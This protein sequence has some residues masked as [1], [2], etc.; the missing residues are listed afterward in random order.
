M[1]NIEIPGANAKNNE[2]KKPKIC[3]VYLLITYLLDNN[4]NESNNI[5]SFQNKGVKIFYSEKQ[6][7]ENN[8]EYIAIIENNSEN[9]R[10]NKKYKLEFKIGEKDF[11]IY[12]EYNNAHFIYEL[13]FCSVDSFFK[14]EKQIPQFMNNSQKFIYFFNSIEKLKQ[15]NLFDEL[16]ND[17]INLYSTLPKY[18]FLIN[19]FV[20]VY[21][22][23]NVCPKLLEEFK[24]FNDKIKNNI[25]DKKFTYINFEKYLSDYNN[26][27]EEIS[28]NIDNIITTNSFNSVQF[29]G[30]VLCYLNNYNLE[31]FSKLIEK[32]SSDSKSTLLKIL[33]IYNHFFK[34]IVKFDKNILIELV[35]FSAEQFKDNFINFADKG[36][37]YLNNAN[38]FLNAI[39][40]N[41]EQIILIKD[42]KAILIPN[43]E[44]YSNINLK[45]FQ[46]DF[47]EI[48]S[49]S[50]KEGKLLI[51][52]PNNFWDSLLK[53]YENSTKENINNCKI[54]R[55]NFN[56]YYEL[57][58][59]YCKSSLIK[60]ETEKYYTN[61][62]FAYIL[63]NSI[64]KYL[65]EN[66]DMKNKEIV[67][68]IMEYDPYYFPENKV[69]IN[70][71]NPEIFQQLNISE[72]D[73]DFKNFYR[74]YNFEQIF[75]DKLDSY[76]SL[77]ISKIKN[78][79]HFEIIIDLIN[80]DNIGD[81]LINFVDLLDKKYVSLMKRIDFINESKEEE[82]IN[83]MVNP[84][85]KLFKF[86][87]QHIDLE[88]LKKKINL[89]MNERMKIE[90]YI[91]L[92]EIDEKGIKR[93]IEDK[94]IKNLNSKNLVNLI[95]FMKSIN[96][97]EDYLNII[98]RLLDKYPISEEIFLSKEEDIGIELLILLKENNLLIKLE[99]NYYYANII[100]LFEK[101]YN[102]IY[103]KKIKIKEL[104]SF[105]S[106]NEEYI[107]KKLTLLKNITNQIFEPKREYNNLKSTQT[108]IK[109]NYDNLIDI[110]NALEKYH[111][112]TY[113][114]TLKTIDSYIDIINNGELEKYD[115]NSIKLIIG[116][117]KEKCTNINNVKDSHIF[118]LLYRHSDIKDSEKRF[119]Q[120]FKNFEKVLYIKEE[121]EGEKD[122]EAEELLNLIKKELTDNQ[123]E[124]EK[125]L[126]IKKI[127]KVS[128]KYLM[129]IEGNRHQKIINSIF[130]FFS[131]F[132][133][134]DDN[135]NKIFSPK[136]KDIAKNDPQDL[137]QYLK[138]LKQNEIYDYSKKENY[139]NFFL[140][141]Y[142]LKEAYN[143]LLNETT[144]S[145]KN[146][147]GKIDPNNQKIKF[148]DIEDT[149]YCVGFFQEIKKK[150]NNIEIFKFI[151]EISSENIERFHIF[152][153]V[154]PSIIELNQNNELSI[155]LYG[156]IQDITNNS[157]FK[158]FKDSQI[159][160]YVDSK[161]VEKND[162]TLDKLKN[163]YNKIHI[164]PKENNSKT[165]IE[166]NKEKYEE[167]YKTLDNFKTLVNHIEVI[168][169][170][171]D[172]LRTKGSSLPIQIK[173]TAKDSNIE[174]FLRDEKTTF[175][176]IQNYLFNAKNYTITK[177]EEMY[178]EKSNLRFIYG[179]QFENLM[180]NH[181]NKDRINPFLRYI[182]NNTDNEIKV[183]PGYYNKGKITDD[184]VA[185][186]KLYTD[187][188]FEHISK[189]INSVFEKNNSSYEELYSKMLISNTNSLKGIYLYHSKPNSR[190][191]DNNRSDSFNKNSDSN[192][193][194]SDNNSFDK[195]SYSMEGDILKI[196][197][198]NIGILPVAQN[199]LIS[200]KETS[201]EEIHAFFYRAILCKYNTL[202]IVELNNSF[203]DYKIKIM[204]NILDKLLIYKNKL[205]NE[206][207]NKN[208]E[209]A[210]TN[211]YM[212][213]CLLFIYNDERNEL[214][215]N[216]IQKLNPPN[217][218]TIDKNSNI[219][220]TNSIY[221]ENNINEN[222]ISDFLHNN[223]H[224]ISSEFCGL[225]K[226]TK[227]RDDIKKTK[228]I[229]IYFPLGGNLTKKAIYNKLDEIIYEIKNMTK[230]NYNDIAIHLDLYE[231]KETSILNEFLFCF[232]ITKF[233]TNYENII[234]IPKNIEIYIEIPNCFKDFKSNCNI[235]KF[236]KI[237]TIKF[238]ELPELNLHPEKR[239]LIKNMLGFSTDKETYDYIIK[240]MNINE[241][242]EK[243]AKEKLEKED[244]EDKKKE[245]KR[246]SYHQINI[247]IN[248]FIS[249]YNKFNGQKLKFIEKLK[250]KD[251]KG[252]PIE[253][254][255]TDKC[256]K[257]FA[258]G[259]KYFI[260]GCYA[261]LL[262]KKI[263][264]EENQDYKQKE[265]YYI[266]NLSTIYEEDLENNK[267]DIPVI[268]IIKD[269][270]AFTPLYLSE[271]RL[272]LYEA[273]KPISY[274]EELKYILSLDDD[275]KSL[276]NIIKKNK[277][278]ITLDNFRKMILIL[279]R[280][281]ANIPVILMGETGC[282]K[283]FLIKNLNLLLNH[284]EET[285]KIINIDPSFDD[286]KLIKRMEEINKIAENYLNKNLWVFLDELNTCDSLSLITEIF[287]N[288][289][290]NGIKLKDNIRIIGAC[291]P[292]RKKQPHRQK[293]GLHHPNENNDLIYSVN[294]LPQSLLYFVFN[295]GALKP[296]DEEKYISSIIHDLFKE[297][298]NILKEKT[299]NII[300]KCHKYL[301]NKFDYSVVSLRELSRFTTFCEFFMKEYYVIKN[302]YLGLNNNKE[303]NLIK[304][305]ILS[306][307]ICY[308]TRLINKDQQS[309]FEEELKP[310]ILELVNYKSEKNNN[311]KFNDSNGNLL[312]KIDEPLKS[313][314]TKEMKDN[315][316]ENFSAILTLEEKFVLSQINL[317]KGIGLNRLLRENV[318][319]LFISLVTKVPLIIV[320]KPGSGKSLS[321]QLIFKSMRGEFSKSPFLIRF[322]KIIQSY[323]QGSDSTI[324]EDVENIFQI[325]S[326][327]LKTLDPKKNISMILFDEMGLAEKAKT[328]PLKALH[329]RLEYGG[330]KNEVSFVGISNW[331]L[332][333]AKVN[334]CLLLTVPDL[335]DN[336]DDLKETS[337][338]IA[339]SIMENVGNNEIFNKILPFDYKT[340][341]DTLKE[342]KKFKVYKQYLT[343]EFNSK[344]KPILQKSFDSIFK[345]KNIKY[346][347]IITYDDIMSV[348]SQIEDYFKNNKKIQLN[349]Y[350]SWMKDDFEKIV[351]DKNFSKLYKL[352][353]TIDTDFHGN[354]DYYY[355]IKGIAR[356][357]NNVAN[358]KH[359]VTTII[360]K[361]IERNF[362]GLEIDIENQENYNLKF[363]K[364][365]KIIKDNIPQNLK[366]ITSVNMFKIIHNF[367]VNEN[368]NDKENKP[369][370]EKTTNYDIL[371]NIV[372]NLKDKNCRYCMLEIKPTLAPLIKQSIA[373]KLNIKEDDIKL[374][375]GSPFINDN[376]SEY[377]FKMLDIIQ[378]H[379]SKNDIII[380]Q[381][382]DQIYAFLFDFF[383]MNYTVNNEK[384]YARICHGN[385]SEQLILV[386]ELFK[387]IVMVDKKFMMKEEPPFLN[388]FEKIIISI[389]KLMSRSQRNLFEEIWAND[390]N[391]KNILDNVENIRNINYDLK[392]L[393]IGCKKQDIQGLI[394]SLSESDN[395]SKNERIG[396][397]DEIKRKICDK[398]SKLLP[399]DII[400]NLPDENPVK[401]AYFKN[402]H[403]YKLTDYLEMN[404][405]NDYKISIIYT[406]SFSNI[407]IEGVELSS[408]QMI[409]EIQSEKNLYNLIEEKIRVNKSKN[410]NKYIFLQFDVSQSD[411][412]KFVV[413]FIDNNFSCEEF[414]FYKFILIIHVRRNIK[415]VDNKSNEKKIFLKEA[416]KSFRISNIFD[417]YPNIE[418]LFIDNL[419]GENISLDDILKKPVKNTLEENNDLEDIFFKVLRSFLYKN[420][421]KNNEY[422]DVYMNFNEEINE[423][424][425]KNIEETF[426][427]KER[428]FMNNII[429]KAKSFVLGCGKDIVTKIYKD[430]YVKKNSIDIVS[431]MKNYISDEIF[432]NILSSIFEILEDNNFLTTLMILNSKKE[433]L[434][435]KEILNEIKENILEEIDINTKK[436]LKPKFNTNYFIPGFYQFY[437]Y[438]SGFI[439]NNI[440]GDYIQNEN[441]LRKFIKGDVNEI[442][443]KFHKKETNLLNSLYQ[444][445]K[446]YKN[447]FNII[448][449]DK[450]D[451][452][453]ILKD[454]ITYFL[455][456]YSKEMKL[457]EETYHNFIN[458]I[459]ALRINQKYKIFQENEGNKVKIFLLQVIWLESNKDNI[460][461]LLNI[462]C[463]LKNNFQKEEELI[464]KIEKIINSGK[465]KYITEE[466]RN[467]KHTTE[468]NECFYIMLAS[469]CLSIIQINIQLSN[470]NYFYSLKK[471]LKLIQYLNDNLSLYLNEVF[472]LDTII[473]IYDTLPPKERKN[474]KNLNSKF[475]DIIKNI[476][477]SNEIIQSSNE[478][479]YLKLSESFIK[480]FNLLK[481]I[482]IDE[483]K[484]YY[485][486]LKRIF[487]NEIKKVSDTNYRATIFEHIIKYNETIRSSGD[488]LQILFK[489]LIIPVKDKYLNTIINLLNDKSEIG[490]IIENVLKDES[491][492]NY[493]ALSETLIYFF[494]K[495]SHVYLNNI[496][497]EKPKI[498][499]EE[500][501]LDLFMKAIEYLKH[502]LNNKEKIKNR[503]NQNMVKLFCIA[504]IKSF[505]YT[506]ISMM[507]NGYY[508]NMK[509]SSKIIEAIKNIDLNSKA[510]DK[511]IGKT[512]KLYIYK[513]IYFLNDE[514]FEIFLRNETIIKFKLKEYDF[515]EF[516]TIKENNIFNYQNSNTLYEN[517]NYETFCKIVDKYKQKDF[518]EVNYKEFDLNIGIDIFF[519][520]TSNIIPFY[521]NQDNSKEKKIYLN[522]YKNVIVPLFKDYNH[523]YDKISRA[524]QFFYSEEYFDEIK[525]EFKIEFK[526]LKILLK[527]YRYF[528]NEVFSQLNKNSKSNI[529]YKLYNQSK[530]NLDNINSSYFPGNDIEEKN[531]YNLLSKIE[532]HFSGENEKKGCYVCLCNGKGY[533]HNDNIL[534][535]NKTT[536]NC[537]ECG[538]IL[539]KNESF[540]P[541]FIKLK[542]VKSDTYFRIF[543]D[544]K[545]FENNKNDFLSRYEERINYL[546][547]EQFVNKFVRE[548]FKSEKGITKIK[549]LHLKR[550]NKVIRNLSQVSYRL[551]NFI[552][553]SHLF[554]ARVFTDNKKIDIYLPE[555][556][557]SWMEM[558]TNCWELLN[559]ELN[560]YNINDI[561]AFM[562]YIFCGLFEILKGTK[563]INDY[564]ELI[565]LEEKVEKFISEK[566]KIFSEEDK[567]YK[568]L[569]NPNKDDKL[570][571][572]NL[573]KELYEDC[574][575]Y[576][577]YKYFYYS[578]Y[579][580]EDV[581]LK[582][583]RQ[584]I[585][586]IKYPV[587]T[588]YL[589]DK[590]KNNN[591]DKLSLFNNTLNLF[592]EKYTLNKKREEA[593]KEIL[594]DDEIYLYNNK[595]ID[596]FIKYYNNLELTTEE[597]KKLQLSNKSKL[598]EFFIDD[599]NEIGKSYIDIYQNFIKEQNNE[600]SDLI[601]IKIEQEKFDESSKKKVNIQNIK[602]NEIFSFK[603][604]K[605]FSLINIIFDNSF[606]K[607]LISNKRNHEDYTHFDID[608]KKIEEKMTDILLK[609]KK[610]FNKN[611][612]KFIYKNEDLFFDNIDILQK[613][614]INYGNEE[615]TPKEKLLLYDFYQENKSNANI[616]LGDFKNLI[617][618]LNH[619]KNDEN[620]KINEK[621]TI[622]DCSL[623]FKDISDNFK[624]LFKESDLTLCKLKDLFEYYLMLAFPMLS[625]GLLEIK[626]KLPKDKIDEINKYFNE[627]HLI[628]KYIFTYSIRLFIS[629]FLSEEKNKEN[630]IKNNLNNIINYIDIPDLWKKNIYNTK[631]FR[632]ELRQIKKLNIQLN[633]I[634][635]LNEL[636]GEDFDDIYFLDVQK[637]LKRREDEKNAENK[638]KEKE[639]Q[640]PENEPNEEE[641]E[642]ED[643]YYKKV[644]DDDDEDDENLDNL[645]F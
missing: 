183:E 560:K 401:I 410:K 349:D 228:K 176:K 211:E 197:A 493:L 200:N 502:Y 260:E 239:N 405:K 98:G 179:K 136:Y 482:K 247:F 559:N 20:K 279:Y 229:Y 330:N 283:T 128:E 66:Q 201:F 4:Q 291:N 192:S 402:R 634:Y 576:P 358:T 80:I 411:K 341:K 406:F 312:L 356:D 607:V 361:Y 28:E 199:I 162:L 282:G 42:F 288:R 531:I 111:K 328:N 252:K 443:R 224:V 387:C 537:K 481:K 75:K 522:F 65:E 116:E 266:H 418:Q 177:L 495:N 437:E 364:L 194:I 55:E 148:K 637:E 589:S 477:E 131:Y 558:L 345:S 388:R 415:E 450:I 354:R 452:K 398:I 314:L 471:S 89:I 173:I 115:G 595:Q 237:Q 189:Y 574:E 561:E 46:K 590:N 417:I 2:I 6:E 100:K 118:N 365:I 265:I 399:Q 284:G 324:P 325:A 491:E 191:I 521:F 166:K 248:L 434:L 190:N 465:I 72:I 304:S 51:I 597:G 582:K 264:F 525:D 171:M 489:L 565:K 564:D 36:L 355:L 609:N 188:A 347:D 557:I 400:I 221:S 168:Q 432:E 207:K 462:Y 601:E 393:L 421:Q 451:F 271:K 588:K 585:D 240:I 209:K 444:E 441:K 543:K 245:S 368:S 163:L 613:F 359:L 135:W 499:L 512:I 212:D 540:I 431:I 419:K 429:E 568:K 109:T 642:E 141:L 7:K 272:K 569:K 45:E 285:L 184:Y 155:L 22:N 12:Y 539:W 563:E 152:S 575:Q 249:Q 447:I 469:I 84:L 526:D 238:N 334:R 503:N 587:L 555:G 535:E 446:G 396:N 483:S 570:L 299:I 24:K 164:P 622:Y 488:I 303:L 639:M 636:I 424:L 408:S 242:D 638:D 573:L 96:S 602:D 545:D 407:S 373:K 17:T 68:I 427:F 53:I 409:S 300:S 95:K 129:N 394:F 5:I 113:K 625:K 108:N 251:E 216:E 600:I 160:T 459:L 259:T 624:G 35:G 547:K 106:S 480:F 579:L 591:L 551:L 27:F 21:Q 631:E 236:F 379:A 182:L 632:E 29:Y 641:E 331:S 103:T 32:L 218:P 596:E 145:I 327:K 581:L 386:D 496:F 315:D 26:I 161:N 97:E 380:L 438:L 73:E 395:D 67:K 376:N 319:L 130:Y 476:I 309:N 222:S 486:V 593:E 606:R 377:Q 294:L 478:N 414:K 286:E 618:Q 114:E 146:L 175:D 348:K 295:F 426:R 156:E 137:Y 254:N 554:F 276:E 204:N 110:K 611:I 281:N 440:S 382:L 170:Y 270:M 445:I 311:K 571:P 262:T 344:I 598:Y 308:F 627:N 566:I 267:Y 105:L 371:A 79:F 500:Q 39:N 313:D 119:E 3:G 193:K 124:E 101:I 37:F 258:L 343:D 425:S 167:K 102:Y 389:D 33:L 94:F 510:K 142:E 306:I 112:E 509:N 307:Y 567:I 274:L 293:V 202:F 107:I 263:Q 498:L 231:S 586:N 227:I 422:G 70:K 372:D 337:I 18:D 528:L 580:N 513:I 205:Y 225:G 241:K 507:K 83:K 132:P 158:F 524:L 416:Q 384:N 403:Y 397:K 323:F 169:D 275:I 61:D 82:E 390:L 352:E 99:N 466:T 628:T 472:I 215:L 269:R 413:S 69:H 583:F 506:F 125:N 280:I 297:Q 604:N 63:D 497:K 234:Y 178:K 375:E 34:N 14:F 630:K 635:S 461:L 370:I 505:C 326:D 316:L 25:K 357:L 572:I 369:I 287:I 435:K 213:S 81:K 494:E 138:E 206:E 71:R 181:N 305:I 133:K 541:F 232:L 48:L 423:K 620:C 123:I 536:I 196:F 180:N 43:F 217:F 383:N 487:L 616:I 603:L 172:T 518:E 391:F 460:L 640:N 608:F 527:S 552:L 268:F 153:C 360:E 577:F 449:Q 378:N 381:N 255:I 532:D 464:Q 520:S 126:F 52:F 534:C 90:L 592:R 159:F 243:E 57:F 501:P 594:C 154:Y 353:K 92:Y 88:S 13:E 533:Y 49:F 346:T 273:S 64:K 321:A 278:V 530:T 11:A 31:K 615:S 219:S 523:D 515:N 85:F 516:I 335:E 78:I 366:K 23:K 244:K 329:S 210:K 470:S 599:G 463:Y 504:Y 140:Y 529:Y 56:K 473:D 54:L 290:F 40:L 610:L 550:N 38:I 621:S 134:N 605:N 150:E 623:L 226:S 318:F 8:V 442:E 104:D 301:R 645:N 151:K 174:Y 340:Y 363:F 139:I 612:N 338:S 214:F 121:N 165:I 484:E 584:S 208:V 120:T 230:N 351:N 220:R 60:S 246:F 633:Q 257:Q 117:F 77:L 339:K 44:N 223:I 626:V 492:N 439:S 546:T 479:K 74:N 475:N 342:F 185:E 122:L 374:Y 474:N 235:L 198:E 256:I 59:I 514:Q 619:I 544:E 86:F 87:H 644:K 16:Y 511:L 93:Y 367:I 91:K 261:N 562:D 362:G 629:S 448:N 538:K 617:I 490:K 292:Y 186:Y 144:E 556:K 147:F 453:L 578:N 298:N 277:F 553:Y 127:G 385:Y 47:D 233:Y 149:Y 250:E 332:D 614:Y 187:N 485:T 430:K 542:P 157:K 392:S 517:K 15:E 320:G 296:E 289:S 428:T 433:N 457:S 41:K 1:E 404:E 508:T 467:P 195:D 50:E 456:K 302:D 643:D 412:L 333:A 310:E 62:I 19:I 519:F 468:V 317:E 143:F 350:P 253:K 58:K 322:P 420:T 336:M 549:L 10:K 76:I 203:S 548:E 436:E 9:H 454:Y 455:L 458:L 30:I